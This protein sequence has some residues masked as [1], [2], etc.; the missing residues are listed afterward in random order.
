M[1]FLFPVVAHRNINRFANDTNNTLAVSKP[2]ILVGS[3]TTWAGY[4]RRNQESMN[5][6]IHFISAR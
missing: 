5:E 2:V 3:I 6:G 4:E 1:S